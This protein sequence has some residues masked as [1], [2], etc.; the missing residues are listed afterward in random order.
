[1]RVWID[2]DIGTDVD[3][4]L[5]L[6]YA[7]RHPAIELVGVS[8]VFGDVELRV[9]IVEA[10]LA[11]AA[12]D[13]CPIL[14]GLGKP[15]SPE[16]DG[17]MLGHEGQGLLSDP[18]P[19]LC[20]DGDPDRHGTIDALGRAIQAARPDAL[21]SIGPMTNIAALIRAGVELPRLAVMGGKTREIGIEGPKPL[22]DEWNWFCDSAAVR[23]FLGRPVSEVGLPLLVPAEVT[24][25]TELAPD[26]L[27]I[28]E[29]GDP[30]AR[31]LAELC[32]RW[33]EVLRRLGQPEP[34]VHLHDPLTVALLAAP[35]LCPTEPMR[36]AI[37]EDG[38]TTRCAGPANVAVA[39]DVAAGRTRRLVMDTILGE[40]AGPSQLRMQGT[41]IG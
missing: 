21:V 3:D 38:R 4:A 40:A 1:M 37:S 41:K 24:F 12:V 30:L 2:T 20:T 15:L 23:E 28:L 13:E 19:R 32:R 17:V 34:R 29:K 39:V 36:L 9:R 18:Q 14:A 35:D 6:A 5:A 26:D 11:Q 25:R 7:L 27:V 16:R 8:T 22:I 33:L 31:M 10:L